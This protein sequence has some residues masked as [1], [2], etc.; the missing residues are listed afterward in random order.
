MKERLQQAAQALLGAWRSIAWKRLL[1]GAALLLLTT[2]LG[3]WLMFPVDAVFEL[4]RRKVGGGVS[5]EFGDTSM[6][7]AGPVVEDVKID[8]PVRLAL[9]QVQMRPGLSTL[10][11]NPSVHVGGELGEGWL[12]FE[13]GL[14]SS[15]DVGFAADALSVLDS[16][17]GQS[18]PLGLNLSGTLSALGDLVWS[19][20]PADITGSAWINIDQPHLTG[21]TI[22]LATKDITFKK[23]QL[24]VQ[25]NAGVVTIERLAFDGEEMWGT[26]R[27]SIELD[28]KLSLSKADLRMEFHF[29]ADLDSA[30]GPLLPLAGFRK[31]KDAYVRQYRGPLN[32]IRG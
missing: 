15:R 13:S 27:G 11:F 23:I 29:N 30:I 26:I 17:L 4:V 32:R 8:G 20:N 3:L 14:S 2:L 12:W 25:A 22:P 5:I 19:N 28:R 16:G 18:L 21:E 9:D 10:W 6:G 7:L 31:E 24:E 1:P